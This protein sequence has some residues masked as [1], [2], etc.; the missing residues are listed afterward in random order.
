LHAKRERRRFQR[1]D[2][3][4]CRIYVGEEGPFLLLN[5]SYGGMRFDLKGYSKIE[6]LKQGDQL[7]CDIHLENV[8]LNNKVV[9]RNLSET[10]AGCSFSNLSITESRVLQDFIKPRIIGFS[11]AEIESSGLKYDTDELK[12]RWFA[13]DDGTQVIL[14]QDV[15]GKT[16]RQEFYF[17]DYFMSFN[18]GSG[19]LKTGRVK[20]GMSR[21][22]GRISTDS[23]A[24]FQIPSYRAL[25]LGKTILNFSKLPEEAKIRFLQEIASEEK[26]LYHR[27][28]IKGKPVF[29]VSDKYNAR[30]P[31]LNL[32]LQGMALLKNHEAE[33]ALEEDNEG[34]LILPETEIRVVFSKIYQ[35][36]QIIGGKL[37]CK[38]ESDRTRFDQFLAPRLLAQYFEKAPVPVEPPEFSSPGAVGSLFSG[39]HNTHIL[40]L[41]DKSNTLILGRIAFMD[42]VLQIKNRK[43]YLFN[44]S[45]GIVFPGDW[46]VAARLVVNRRIPDENSI[47]FC[48]EM[49]E[50]FELDLQVR[51]A[52]L[53]LLKNNRNI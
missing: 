45:S 24:F 15:D 18:D 53:N 21:G 39:L 49:L 11:L 51:Q 1:L 34:N 12:L 22:F 7:N 30:I 3:S 17:L 29:F 50:H 2:L 8:L 40:S 10:L 37:I 4:N 27:Y 23:I 38:S 33:F 28:V 19:G 25:K 6:T 47:R 26:R 43:L 9:I 14:W 31:V 32:S 48:V 16:V 41:I 36:S 42:T 35:D 20:A 52:W 5:L 44:C 13:G 46:E